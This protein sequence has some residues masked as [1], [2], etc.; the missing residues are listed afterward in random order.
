MLF[1]TENEDR[2]LEMP[3]EQILG[4]INSLPVRFVLEESIN[5]KAKRA[6]FD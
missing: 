6:R 2:L 3:F 4:Q 1:L 5:A